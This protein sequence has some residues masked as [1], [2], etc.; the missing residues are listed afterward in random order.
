MTDLAKTIKTD[1]VYKTLLESTKAIA[2][3][4][5][6]ATM[7]FAC[8]G[9]QIESLKRV[10]LALGPAATRPRAMPA[11]FRIAVAA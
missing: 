4:I 2:W 5:D 9:P 11:R 6:W 7:Q 3:K 10:A 8:I 1:D